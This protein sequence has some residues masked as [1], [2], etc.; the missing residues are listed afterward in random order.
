M[1]KLTQLNGEGLSLRPN[2]TE[3]TAHGQVHR[4][5]LIPAIPR[6]RQPDPLARAVFW[7][8]LAL[9][10]SS[11]VVLEAGF[12]FLTEEATLVL[13]TP[14]RDVREYRRMRFDNAEA[15]GDAECAFALDLI[16][17]MGTRSSTPHSVG[18]LQRILL[19]RKILQPMKAVPGRGAQPDSL[20]RAA[21]W[22]GRA[23][24]RAGWKLGSVGQ[25]ESQGGF[26]AEI[27]DLWHIFPSSMLPDGTVAASL[28]RMIPSLGQS[29]S[30]DL[31]SLLGLPSAGQAC[32]GG[33]R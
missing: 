16:W 20:V 31:E 21:Y 22:Q 10:N 13:E 29:R 6:R 1:R 18:H 12:D 11:Y 23:L 26:A 25:P 9:H 4:N 32:R 5:D 30:S 28:A 2:D 33:A 14:E 3:F 19:R 24:G 8:L 15:P 7:Q 17:G 27:G